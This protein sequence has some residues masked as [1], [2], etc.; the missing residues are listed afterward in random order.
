MSFKNSGILGQI[1]R[2]IQT[3]CYFFVHIIFLGKNVFPTNKV[4]SAPKPMVKFC[5]K[6]S[7][8]TSGFSGN[9]AFEVNV[10]GLYYHL[11]VALFVKKT[12]V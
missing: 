10:L 7:W 3:P 4:N 2:K 1:S 6:I 12:A 9:L 5:P 8:L 11:Y